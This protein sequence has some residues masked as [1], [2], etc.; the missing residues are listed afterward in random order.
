[1]N[2]LEIDAFDVQLNGRRTVAFAILG[3]DLIVARVL[4]RDLKDFQEDHMC[5]AFG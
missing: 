1:M 2:R 5:V 3:G 4:L